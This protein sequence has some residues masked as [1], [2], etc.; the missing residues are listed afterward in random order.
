MWWNNQN[1]ESPRTDRTGRVWHVR[2]WH[3]H[4]SDVYVQRIFFWDDVEAESGVIELEGNLTVH[5]SRLK[6]IISKLLASAEYRA[7]YRRPLQF[8]V[9][10]RYG[11]YRPLD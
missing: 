6:Q 10:R 9:E 5:I 3:G 2:V 11:S 8:P 1:L 4:V 7:Q